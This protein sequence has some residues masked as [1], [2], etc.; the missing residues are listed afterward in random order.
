MLIFC[1]FHSGLPVR[2]QP[3]DLQIPCENC[4]Y[5][6][7]SLPSKH[8]KKYVYAARFVG[9]VK[10]KT[11][12]VTYF[13]ALGKCQLMETMTDFEIRYYSGAKLLRSP[14][15]G[16]KV[17]NAN[18]MLLSDHACMEARSLIEHGNECFSHCAAVSNALEVAQTKDSSC[19]PVTIGRRPITDVQPPQKFDGLRDTTNTNFA[20]STPKSNQVIR[21]IIFKMII[22][23][24]MNT[25]NFNSY[26]VQLTFQLALFRRSE[27]LQI[28]EAITRDPIY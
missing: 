27:I 14:T 20:F 26:R 9:L 13:S 15:E 2:E 11:P 18:G 12:K 6:Y 22:H 4:V 17:Y 16:V 7:D 8:W 23:F 1:V 25:I 19:F 21:N 5:N 28:S 10:S 24:L 3:P